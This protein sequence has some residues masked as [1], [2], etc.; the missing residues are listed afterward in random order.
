[1]NC[2][3]QHYAPPQCWGLSCTTGL[4]QAGELTAWGRRLWEGI[5]K[6]K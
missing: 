3:C 1:M 4:A 6:G 5:I 2:H